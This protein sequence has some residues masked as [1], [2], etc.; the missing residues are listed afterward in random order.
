MPKSKRATKVSLTQTTKKKTR[1]HKTKYVDTVRSAIDATDRIYLFSYENMRSTHFK[2]VRL[3]FRGSSSSSAS[4]SS[5]RTPMDDDDE[6]EGDGGGGGGRLFLGKNKLLQIALG[7]TSSDEYSDNT[8]QISTHI[9]GSVGILC[10]TMSSTAV[11]EYFTSLTIPEYAKY[12]TP[13]SQTI[14]LTSDLITNYPVCMM[15]LFRKLGLPVEIQ[16]GNLG[17][18]GGR[19]SYEVC[20]K[21]KE[22]T[23]EQ[24]K[25]LVH[26]GIKLSV[27]KIN[28]LRRWE[29]KDGT[30]EEL[31]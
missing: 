11:E 30:I 27:F 8:C 18:V 14:T 4:S 3:H 20:T 10:T 28:L 16:N 7:R 5:G 21:G 29:K 19:T 15:E 26:M 9:T 12:G 17:F 24:C 6:E 22:L 2:D 13:A 25:I 1:D 23:V 31:C